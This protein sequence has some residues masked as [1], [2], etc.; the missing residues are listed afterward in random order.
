MDGWTG[1]EKERKEDE[2]EDMEGGRG[3]KYPS[4]R[5][6][7]RPSKTIPHTRTSLTR[8]EVDR[9]RLVIVSPFPGLSVVQV[10]FLPSFQMSLFRMHA[11]MLRHSEKRDER[12]KEKEKERRLYIDRYDPVS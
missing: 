5:S 3:G 4:K 7:Q 2:D 11:S 12:K 8:R 10:N 1:Y 9:I 6:A